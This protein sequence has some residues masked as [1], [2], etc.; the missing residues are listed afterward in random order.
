M[1]RRP[2]VLIVLGFLTTTGAN[3]QTAREG[4]IPSPVIEPAVVVAP[5]EVRTDRTVTFHLWAPRAVAVGVNAGFPPVSGPDPYVMT[6]NHRGVWNVTV[7]PLPPDIWS[8]QFLVDGLAL[9]WVQFEVPASEP[10]FY[11][12]RPVRRGT[13][14]ISQYESKTLGLQRFVYVYTPPGYENGATRYPALYLLHPAG[15]GPSYWIDGGLAHVILDNLIA[16]NKA[17]PMVIV[18]PFGYPLASP[19]FGERVEYKENHTGFAADFLN[20]LIPFVEETYRVVAHPDQ[21]AIAGASMGGLQALTLGLAHLDRFGWIGGFSGLGQLKSE[22]ELNMTFAETLKSP[23]QINKQIGALWF[24]AGD[25]EGRVLAR[26]Q[27]FSTLLK[28]RGIRHTFVTA[29]GW[30]HQMQ[31]W[32]RNLYEFAQVLFRP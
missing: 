15:N 18:M 26:N 2:L 14:H 8:Y 30:S 28:Q 1:F 12:E 3:A 4:S 24:S 13:V 23:T 32:R 29:A 22:I 31:S 9:G 7:G 10:Q 27:E 19:R 17:K 20:D 16:G 11:N 21:R 25:L 5:V 6:K